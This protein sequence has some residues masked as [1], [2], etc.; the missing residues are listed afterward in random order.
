MPPAPIEEVLRTHT[1]DWMAVPGVVGTGIGLC[2]GGPC[3]KVFAAE[4]TL[5]IR[6]RIP[7]SVEGYPV[8]IE[9]TGSFRA[10]QP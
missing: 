10:R 9:T 3:L 8:M 4:R 2:E 6:E 7:A 1:P 5:E